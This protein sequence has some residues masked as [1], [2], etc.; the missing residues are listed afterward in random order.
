[1]CVCVCV[2]VC[3]CDEKESINFNRRFY[4]FTVKL[5]LI[6][7]CIIIDCALYQKVFK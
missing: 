2:C 7:H 5:L 3:V 6:V 1:M 4:S